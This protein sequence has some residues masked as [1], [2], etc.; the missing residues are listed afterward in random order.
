MIIEGSKEKKIQLFR[1][2]FSTCLIHPMA[3]NQPP[4]SEMISHSFIDADG[5]VFL[6]VSEVRPVRNELPAPWS[7]SAGSMDWAL[8]NVLRWDG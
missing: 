4:I 7:L 1:L 5:G 3:P 6:C 8:R 2:V